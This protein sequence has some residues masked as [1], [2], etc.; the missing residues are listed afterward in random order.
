MGCYLKLWAEI[1]KPL[2][3]AVVW[4]RN[5]PHSLVYLFEHWSPVG[6]T[7]WGGRCSFAGGSVSRGAGFD[8]NSL[9]S[10]PTH[11]VHCACIWRCGL[12]AP[13]SCCLA[14]LLLLCFPDIIDSI[15]LASYSFYTLPWSWYYITATRKNWYTQPSL[16][17][18]PKTWLW[19]LIVW[20]PSLEY[21][22]FGL[23]NGSYLI[24]LVLATIRVVNILSFKEETMR[25]FLL[26]VVLGI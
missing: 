1:I 2:L 23:N 13:G 4:M 11:S 20:E 19:T 17:T 22:A 12:S 21:M 14:C 3:P 10:L 6:G 25:L 8:V 24:L 18:S 7:L 5:A 9:E 15:P 16:V 26:F